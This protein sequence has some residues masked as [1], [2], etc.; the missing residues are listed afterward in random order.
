MQLFLRN[1]LWE[2]EGS[3]QVPRT[4]SGSG[5]SWV[6]IV[7]AIQPKNS[8]GDADN[9]QIVQNM[10]E[11]KRRLDIENN[12]V[13]F[14]IDED[15]NWLDNVGGIF[16]NLGIETNISNVFKKPIPFTHNRI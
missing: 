8:E 2:K 5:K 14:G 6:D 1:F 13:I 12:V 4:A 3:E 7:K 15:R 9:E 10:L 16:E 11:V